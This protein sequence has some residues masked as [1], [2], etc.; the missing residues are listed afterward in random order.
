M[1]SQYQKPGII[2]VM[3]NM[4]LY[5]LL[6]LIIYFAG[7]RLFYM[8]DVESKAIDFKHQEQA[9]LI[10]QQQYI[11]YELQ[12]VVN[13]L[14]VMI[15][16]QYAIDTSH[17]HQ[18]ARVEFNK[19]LSLL[20]SNRRNYLRARIIDQEGQAQVAV[21]CHDDQPRVMAETELHTVDESLLAS[22]L[23]NLP[24][25]AIYISDIQHDQGSISVDPYIRIAAALEH[26]N[27]TPSQFIVVDYLTQ[28]LSSSL[29]EGLKITNTTTLGSALILTNN[30]NFVYPFTQGNHQQPV[31]VS[32][33]INISNI[34]WFETNNEFLETKQ[35]YI[36]RLLLSPQSLLS[37]MLIRRPQVQFKTI[38]TDESLQ[39]S[40]IAIADKDSLTFGLKSF[41]IK[42]FIILILSG[43]IF[44][45]V[46][47]AFQRHRIQEKSYQ[48]RLNDQRSF[49]ITIMDSMSSAVVATD[50]KGM[51]QTIN[52][53][54]T[55]IFGFTST[56]LLNR[57]A[58][59]LLPSSRINKMG[60][61]ANWLLS[62]SKNSS[63]K[64]EYD[65]LHKDGSW[66]PLELSVNQSIDP[67]NP[68]Y[69]LV[70][71]D[72][73]DRKEV[74][75]EMKNLHQKYIHREKL[76]EVG[77]LVGGILHEVSNPLAS[78]NGLLA[79]LLHKDTEKNKPIFDEETTN[80]FNVVIDHIER[81]RGLSYEVSSFLRPTSNEMAL[82]D[83]NSVIHTT[84]SLIRFDHR[85][86][87]ID[88]NLEL[89]S[90]LPPIRAISDQLVQVVMNLLVNAADACSTL[91]KREPKITLG[92]QFKDHMAQ[93]YIEDNGVGMDSETIRKIFQP[94]FTTK[95]HSGGTGLG[96]PLCEGIINDHGGHM[97]ITST[98]NKG[99]R[100]T[101]FLPI[102]NY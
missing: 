76:A 88:L 83:L 6:F 92:S 95:G 22:T 61:T 24:L 30:K 2:K 31:P 45:P 18:D 13:D 75:Q 60:T 29:N 68:F 48:L 66:I 65:A 59:P 70:L 73:S 7:I 78:V 41:L 79:N 77:L 94:F 54:V 58:A 19:E 21:D 84:T 98:I 96:M 89:D 32:N 56:E 55:N 57:D 85:W 71:R 36:N 102:N 90:Q 8:V 9:F 49:L 81:V 100:I 39:W 27:H 67:R 63:R 15:G 91:E 40:L 62:H 25:D 20:C 69:L 51:I 3:A 14:G 52:P 82:T 50:Q 97:E 5:T 38:H 34:N 35:H 33:Y 43:A 72:T 11:G 53:A 17:Q 47:F 16:H 37:D 12:S 44:F 26:H 87:D 86:R 101:C 10:I 42:S 64:I 99:T 93:V 1:I 4:K 74:E 80:A 23:N 46:A 28:D